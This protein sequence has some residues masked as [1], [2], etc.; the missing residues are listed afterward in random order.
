MNTHNIIS[1]PDITGNIGSCTSKV[2]RVYTYNGIINSNGYNLVTNS[3]TGIV[4]QTDF[5][6]IQLL[7]MVGAFVI[8]FLLVIVALGWAFKDN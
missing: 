6:E 3:C 8:A 7:G 2:E 5:K 1:T 4:S